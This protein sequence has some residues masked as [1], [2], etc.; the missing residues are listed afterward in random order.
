[1]LTVQVNLH[2]LPGSSRKTYG[3]PRITRDLAAGGFKACRNTVAKIMRQEGLCGRMPRRFIPRTTESAHDHPIAHNTLDRQFAPGTG[4]PAWVSDITY[5]P[6]AQGWLYL[7]AIMDLRTRKIV[8]WAMAD[9]MRVELA[10]DA[11]RMALARRQ[12]GQ[13]LLHH[14]DRGTQY[15]CQ[16]YRLLLA[17]HQITCSM[18]R[19]G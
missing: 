8:G 17:Q 18:S 15:A 7:A 13:N 6:T 1:M 3:S 2:R 19:I 14:S 10:L 4:T 5:I 9:H 16:D 11:L 12:P